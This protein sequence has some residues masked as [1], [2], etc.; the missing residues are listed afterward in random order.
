MNKPA[1]K[2]PSMDE[3]L[4]SIRQIIADEDMRGQSVAASAADSMPAEMAS[5]D[6]TEDEPL[7]LS[8]DQML[9]GNLDDDDDDE[10]LTL[11]EPAPAMPVAPPEPVA[12][13]QVLPET[14]MP[15]MVVGDD[16]TFEDDAAAIEPENAELEPHFGPESEVEDAPAF[17]SSVEFEA[18]E[19]PIAASAMPDPGLSA[20]L[21][22]E[23]LAPATNAAVRSTMSKLSPR[24]V[25]N[26]GVTLDDMVREMMRPMIKAWLDENMPSM[27]ERLVEREISRISRGE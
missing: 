9:T 13:S 2:E 24:S 22:E 3:I 6:E 14:D 21:A 18:E 5:D 23:L 17:A 12:P 16:V 11:S 25:V 20:S 8:T 27:V 19:I 1:A 10:P 4:S 26:S 15:A 7:T